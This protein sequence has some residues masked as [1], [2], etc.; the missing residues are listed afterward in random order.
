MLALVGIVIFGL[1]FAFFATINTTPITINLGYT[2]LSQ[3][4]LYVAIFVS[5]GAGLLIAA[6]IYMGKSVLTFFKV[7]KTEHELTRAKETITDLTKRVH[8]L[9]LENTKLKTKM[10]EEEADEDSL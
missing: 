10:G 4:P 8:T 9:E 7:G 3:I 1:I 6:L 5:L 2:T